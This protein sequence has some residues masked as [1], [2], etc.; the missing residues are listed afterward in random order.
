MKSGIYKLQ[1]TAQP[2]RIYIGSA[3]NLK[4]RKKEHK[5]RLISGVHPNKRLL[6]H[7]KKYGI[8]DLQFIVLELC[9]Q[10]ELI[11]K[12]QHYINT[13]NPSF[14]ICRIAGNTAGRPQSKATRL[15]RSKSMMGRIM[16]EEA[17]HLMRVAVR[18]RHPIPS[19]VNGF[20]ILS[21]TLNK[22]FRT[23][24]YECPQCGK[25]LQSTLY[26]LTMRKKTH[27]GCVKTIKVKPPPKPRKSPTPHMHDNKLKQTNTSGY[28]GITYDKDVK[29]FRARVKRKGKLMHVGNYDTSEE[30]HTHRIAYIDALSAKIT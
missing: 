29:K 11:E 21:V 5:R 19:E 1:S 17:K 4:Q 15:K 16:S 25:E 20:K 28:N 3:I 23:I 27:C 9:P 7:V 8:N 12:E 26:T 2:S 13:L 18:N 10:G 22:H 14:N 6:G 24:V 30:A